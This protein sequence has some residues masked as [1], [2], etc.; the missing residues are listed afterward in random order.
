[1]SSDTLKRENIGNEF[2]IVIIYDKNRKTSQ[3]RSTMDLS[4]EMIKRLG[5]IGAPHA[6]PNTMPGN[7]NKF[8]AA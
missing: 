5:G 7:S 2:T 3:A 4:G 1:V 6:T 8:F